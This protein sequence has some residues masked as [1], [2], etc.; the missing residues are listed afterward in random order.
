[1]KYTVQHDYDA[2]TD[3]RRYGPWVEGD[4]VDL[5]P[6]QADW[7][8]SD[9]AGTLKPADAQARAAAKK[10]NAANASTAKD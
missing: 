6:E 4:E 10:S 7:V 5:E 1:M 8:N 9:S 3:G 2:Y